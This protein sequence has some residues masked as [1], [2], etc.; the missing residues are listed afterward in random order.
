MARY[1]EYIPSIYSWL[2]DIPSHW[3]EKSIRQITK[4]SSERLENRNLPLLSVYREYGV[5]PKK[6]RDDNHNVESSDLSNYKV[7]Y[8]DN[9]VLNKMKMWQGSLGVSK[10]NG[11]VSP[12]YIVCKIVDE[13]LNVRFLHFLLRTA[14]YKT[15][16]NQYSYGIRVGQWDMHY[17]DLKNMKVYIPPL[18]EQEQ[19]VRFLDWK[20]SEINKLIGIKQK[21]ISRL[22]ELQKAVI[23][24]TV[25]HGLNKNA[26]MKFSGVEWIG[27]I[28][29]H[30]QI[31]KLKRVT[32][33]RNEKGIY[34]P[35]ITNRYIGLENVKSYSNDIIVTL[36][37]YDKSVQ[38]ICCK[39]DL[40]FS[41]LR[42]YLA[43][44]IIAPYDS[45]CTG[46]MLIIS[47]FDGDMR[48]LRYLMLHESFI[49]SVDSSTYGAK[50]PRAN[51][52]YIL[53]MQLPIP[54]IDEQ[55]EI[56]NYIDEKTLKIDNVVKKQLQIIAELQELKSS[57]I[58]DVVT[59]KIDVRNVEIPEYEHI[60]D[61]VDDGEENEEELADAE[62][63]EL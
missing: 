15:Y 42:P 57:L 24:E 47:S 60:D 55:R 28:P 30:W 35:N 17:E 13:S 50:M 19:I 14:K 52:N 21:K 12:A 10:Y 38:S 54:Q 27:N 41:K 59:G 3:E 16:Y 33:V 7:V 22:T 37:E 26:P 20:V 34:E 32:T 44:V 6:S 4:V 5:I 23:N 39:G 62:E 45:F 18:T 9:L 49:N 48:F 1:I 61:V 43:K 8:K 29:S 25:T 56:A 51:P 11:I 63:T 36:S 46:E 2:G 31:N 53:N 40:M 58:S